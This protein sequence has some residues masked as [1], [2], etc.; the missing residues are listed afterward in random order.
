MKPYEEFLPIRSRIYTNQYYN[1]L[2]GVII[3]FHNV[4]FYPA[5]TNWTT[6]D[7]D[8]NDTDFDGTKEPTTPMDNADT[9]SGVAVLKNQPVRLDFIE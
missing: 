2:N 5:P 4:S 3:G 1:R 8:A 6:F 7:K 9:T